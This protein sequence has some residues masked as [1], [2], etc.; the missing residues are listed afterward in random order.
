M[1]ELKR[2]TSFNQDHLNR[3]AASLGLAALAL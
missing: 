2:S 3:G 1:V